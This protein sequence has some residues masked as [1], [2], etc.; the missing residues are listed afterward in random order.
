M[1]SAYSIVQFR[2]NGVDTLAAN[3][4]PFSAVEVQDLDVR[5]LPGICA[6]GRPC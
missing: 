3:R 4:E 5:K 1:N 6:R 2:E